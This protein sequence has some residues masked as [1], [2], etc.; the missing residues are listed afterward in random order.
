[1]K[2]VQSRLTQKK[3]RVDIL[4]SSTIIVYALTL[5]VGCGKGVPDCSDSDTKELVLQGADFN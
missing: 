3:F 4:K 5:V 1:M 2:F